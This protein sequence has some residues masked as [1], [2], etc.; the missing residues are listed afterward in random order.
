MIWAKNKA[1]IV[2]LSNTI[3]LDDAYTIIWYGKSEAH[4]YKNGQYI[5]YPEYDYVFNVIQKRYQDT[6]KSIKTLHRNHESYDGK[7]GA[8]SQSMCFEVAYKR[9]WENLVSQLHTTL[10]D[11]TGIS[12]GEFRKQTLEMKADI[13]KYAPYN[14]IRIN[15]EYKYEEGLLIETVELFKKLPDGSELP[16]MKNEESA[17]FYLRWKLDAAPTSL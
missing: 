10:G 3:N 2:P 7:G 6:W 5:R 4:I 9:E 16:F 15:Q 12:D 1:V 14:M 17:Y 11:G 13:S 8:R